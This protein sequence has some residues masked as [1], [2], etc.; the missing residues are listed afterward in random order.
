[1]M[2][3]LDDLLVLAGIG[4]GCYLVWS[5]LVLLFKAPR[6]MFSDALAA[7]EIEDDDEDDYRERRRRRERLWGDGD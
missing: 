3:R 6:G 1:M 4:Y 7:A 2:D 5:F